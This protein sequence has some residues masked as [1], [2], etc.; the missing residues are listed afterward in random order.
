MPGPTLPAVT[1]RGHILAVRVC[2][3]PTD[4]SG[5]V[6]HRPRKMPAAVRDKLTL[7]GGA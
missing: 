7:P 3:A 2:V 6:S 5:V 1:P 4:F